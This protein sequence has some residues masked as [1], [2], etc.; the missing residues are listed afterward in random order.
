MRTTA[1]FA[2]HV[3]A[4]AYEPCPGVKLFPRCD[5]SRRLRASQAKMQTLGFIDVL[6]AKPPDL[7]VPVQLHLIIEGVG[8]QYA[9]GDDTGF[10]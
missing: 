7:D 5:D 4:V 10:G 6:V 1:A 2:L 8:Y 9:S 3:E